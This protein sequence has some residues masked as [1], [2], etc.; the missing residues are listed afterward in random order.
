MK[1]NLFYVETFQSDA[2]RQFTFLEST[3]GKKRNVRSF[4]T[5]SSYRSLQ[6][7]LSS[8]SI[9]HN[10]GPQ[11]T[12]GCLI[13]LLPSVILLSWFIYSQFFSQNFRATISRFFALIF[14]FHDIFLFF[15][16]ISGR[17]FGKFSLKRKKRFVTFL[18]ATK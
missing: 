2:S 6:T 9:H 3:P 14:P 13:R 8:T 17:L 1:K 10:H 12:S 15:Q 11:I 4:S 7:N 18:T 16:M 5:F